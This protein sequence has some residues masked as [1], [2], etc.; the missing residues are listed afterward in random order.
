[1]P[2][3][4]DTTAAT[5]EV[6]LAREQADGRLPSAVAGVVRDGEL[7]WSAGV[8]DVDGAPPDA[9]TQYRIG[10]ITKT[11]VAVCVL[12]LRDEG[13]LSLED[14]IVD[15]VLEAPIDRAT[16]AQLLSHA[17]GLRAE[18]AGP[19][20]ERTPGGSWQALTE[21][22]G[23]AAAAHPP[24]RRFHYSNVGYAVLGELLARRRGVAWHEVVRD[25]LLL[26]LGMQ[27]T[28]IRPAAP[29]A[30]GF[31]V[32]P[33]ADVLLPEP[34][35]DAV[36]MAPAGQLWST[37]ADLARWAAFLGG[38]TDGLLSEDTLAELAR[39]LVVDD[40]PGQP[41]TAAHGLGVQVW[42][43]GGQ[44]LIGHGGSMPGFLATVQVDVASGDGVVAAA[45]ATSGVGADLPTDLLAILVDAEPRPAPTWRP[46]DPTSVLELA[47]VWYWGPN[48]LAL[49]VGRD[50]VLDLGP[51][52]GA[53]RGSRF[54]P[55]D[56]GTWLGCDGYYA[57]ET[58]RVVHHDD[59]TPAHLDLAS[60]VL[61]RAP[62]DPAAEVP[63]G[64][65]P[66]GWRNP[67]R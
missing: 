46:A 45:N 18:T 12:R 30:R 66:R 20:W 41:W 65:D 24:G 64:V 55:Q 48:P 38:A 34:E 60:F 37:I 58:L 5:L 31:A 51:V 57:G 10:S 22:L 11:F 59:G 1:L 56:D 35:H 47:G 39:P 53:G 67:A 4:R 19:W 50:D 7:V 28:T 8:G 6:R 33:Y 27:R 25:E 40:R 52:E 17:A 21:A 54:R 3:V 44:R 9:N 23:S 26:P 49:H 32:H 61:T 62:Y 42:N 13:R 43:R 29:S 14:P 36:A 16:I 2:T 15:H 63:G